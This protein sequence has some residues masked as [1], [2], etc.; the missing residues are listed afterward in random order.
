M[1][2]WCRSRAVTYSHGIEQDLCSYCL[3]RMEQAA[4]REATWEE[5]SCLMP[6]HDAIRIKYY[7]EKEPVLWATVPSIPTYQDVPANEAPRKGASHPFGVMHL[8][9]D[10][11]DIQTGEILSE[12]ELPAQE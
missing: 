6:M 5:R 2:A 8:G 12:D 3:R 9:T 10:I 11:I 4:S 7:Y 1:C